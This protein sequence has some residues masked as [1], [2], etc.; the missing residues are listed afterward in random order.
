[1][2]EIISKLSRDSSFLRILSVNVYDEKGT[3]YKDRVD[4]DNI[5]FY[6][7]YGI[8]LEVGSGYFDN[9]EDNFS[10][11]GYVVSR[12]KE[13]LTRKENFII[14]SKK[15]IWNEKRYTLY[16][17]DKN[18]DV[19]YIDLIKRYENV[20]KLY[21]VNGVEILSFVKNLDTKKWHLKDLIE[22]QAKKIESY[23]LPLQ[24]EEMKEICDNLIK[25]NKMLLEEQEFI[26]NYIPK[27]EDFEEQ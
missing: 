19:Q 27:A 7:E 23:K 17:Y 25:Y 20:Y 13:N 4:L 2:K 16:I 22:E 6:N 10:F 9:D 21:K 12:R 14:S 24:N 3:E 15:N 18:V 5:I 1:M 11:K 26:K 8:I